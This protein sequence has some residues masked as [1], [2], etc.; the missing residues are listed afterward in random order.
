MNCVCAS[1]GLL[2][3]EVNLVFCFVSDFFVS[4][5][6]FPLEVIKAIIMVNTSIKR[7]DINK[8]PITLVP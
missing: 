1:V 4:I 7:I 5:I 3:F 2:V 8:T 6:P